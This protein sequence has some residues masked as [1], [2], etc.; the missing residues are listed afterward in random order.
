[1]SHGEFAVRGSIVDIFPMGAE[2]PLRPGPV[3]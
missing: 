3:R 1:M 2:Q